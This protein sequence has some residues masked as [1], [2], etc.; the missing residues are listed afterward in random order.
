M[1]PILSKQ[2]KS[3]SWCEALRHAIAR[4]DVLQHTTAVKRVERHSLGQ[5]GLNFLFLFRNDTAE[6]RRGCRVEAPRSH[7]RAPAPAVAI[8]TFHNRPPN[9]PFIDTNQIT[10]TAK[11]R[12]RTLHYTHKHSHK[13]DYVRFLVVRMQLK[14]Y[15]VHRPYTVLVKLL[16]LRYRVEALRRSRL[17]L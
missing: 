9:C 15:T 2:T 5:N 17:V 8:L 12:S 13:R 10:P 16:L 7:Q 14:L 6:R 4:E 3:A 11:T 1:C